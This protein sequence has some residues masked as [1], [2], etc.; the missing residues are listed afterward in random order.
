[1]SLIPKPVTDEFDS[2][3]RVVLLTRYP[4][5]LVKLFLLLVAFNKQLLDAKG[6]A[7]A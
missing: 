3:F 2:E 4:D 6:K 5:F 7:T 1:M